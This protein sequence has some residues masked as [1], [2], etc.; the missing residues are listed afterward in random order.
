MKPDLVQQLTEWLSAT[1]IG[2]ME[3]R[4][5]GVQLC[6]RNDGRR[7]ERVAPG[8]VTPVVR[9]SMAVRAPSVGRFLHAHPARQAPLAVPGQ[10]VTRGQT[11]GLLQVGVLLLP[12][13]APCDGTVAA[14]ATADGVVIG[15]GATLMHLHPAEPA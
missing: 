11:I 13:Q 2:W 9:E 4:G 10:P 15:Y 12:V 5:P 3:L 14:H 1:D 7:V 6:L 8:S